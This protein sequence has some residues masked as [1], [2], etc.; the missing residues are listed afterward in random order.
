MKKLFLLLM[1]C[2]CHFLNA[3]TKDS[4]TY[5]FAEIAPEYPGGIDAMYQFI[6]KNVNYPAKEK[7]KGVTAKVVTRFSISKEGDVT[8]IAILSKT[9]EA[10][11]QEV[12]R[13]MKLMPK[14]KP[15]IV[16]GQP[17]E[18]YFTLPVMFNLEDDK[19]VK[20]TPKNIVAEYIGIV[21]GVVVGVLIYTLFLK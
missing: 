9:P 3:Q 10:F 12:I 5:A 14:W 16:N 18:V 20:N 8:N 15:G 13:V 2:M 11:N 7:W 4:T 21:C 1:L 6:S 19:P 17:V